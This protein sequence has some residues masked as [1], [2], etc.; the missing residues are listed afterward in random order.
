MQASKRSRPRATVLLLA[1]AAV[2]S[3]YDAGTRWEGTP[4][5]SAPPKP[6]CVVGA[7]RCALGKIQACATDASGQAVWND[8]VDCSAK[9]LVCAP[10]LLQ[11]TTCVPDENLCQGQQSMVC[12]HDGSAADPVA[13]CDATKGIACRE[14][15]C[16]DLC[17]L[18]AV[19][20]SNIGCEYWAADLDNAVI[21]AA[22]DAAEQQYAIVVS[23]AQPDVS[24][25]VH[26][27]QD[28]SLPGQANA[29]YEVQSATIAPYNLQVFKLGPRE[30]DG[31][32][33]GQYNTGTGTAVTRHAFRVVTDFPVTAYQFNPLDNVNVFSND[34]SLLKPR[35]ALALATPGLMQTQY[36]VAG[37]PQT[38]AITDDPN[39]NFSASN[40]TNLRAFLAVIGTAPNTTVRVHTK[41]TVVPGGPI[42]TTPSGGVVEAM[43]GPYDV[44]NLETG[45][46]LADFTGS[47]VEA[48]QPVVVFS[49]SECS[50]APH[51]TTI[52]DRRCC[53][54]HLENQL[55]P[56]R[57]AGKRFAVAHNP[58]RTTAIHAAG[59]GIVAN[60]E[61]DFVRFVA[62]R[63][64]GA[65]IK[66]TL[67]PPNDTITLQHLGDS[68]EVT[69]YGHFMA[70]S[71]APIHVA[72]VM[73]SQEA[74]GIPI[75]NG[76]PGG[77]PSLVIYPPIEQFRPHYVFLTPDKYVFNFIEILAPPDAVVS[78]DGTPPSSF[79]CDPPEPADG[80][81]TVQRK[82][83]PTPP[84]VVH[85]CQLSFPVIN[86]TAKYPDNVSP[87]VQ[88]NG[89]HRVDADQPVGVIVSGFDYRV[90]YAYPAGTNLVDITGITK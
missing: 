57:T 19:Q 72:Q 67:A 9:G 4:P 38:I 58:S 66:T 82:G 85:R 13:M 52:A 56:L 68:R 75:S 79:G 41:A 24:V 47:V 84:F 76:L 71:S 36:V 20:L 50:D 73:P 64:S 45:D 88:H 10:T 23:N 53:C 12:R 11:C 59:G 8:M 28:D 39:T 89:V 26:V 74:A 69:V 83:D 32:P 21:N 5:P 49:G 3:C 65:V 31:S 33:P 16:Q 46:F 60:P 63:T 51:F 17:G 80:L 7:Q 37:W 14:G 77:D 87:G 90:S 2:A 27:F 22:D 61:P 25:H 62:A 29:P 48:D 34:A 15:T 43:V 44:L 18:A 78:V 35:E 81:T 6:V 40:P 1:F 30:V 54:D 55:D 86:P 42:P 70:E